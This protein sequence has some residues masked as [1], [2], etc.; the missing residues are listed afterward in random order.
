[1]SKRTAGA[2]EPVAQLSLSQ[3][4]AAYNNSNN[5]NGNNGSHDG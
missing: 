3:E 5:N 4:L 2:A 1:M